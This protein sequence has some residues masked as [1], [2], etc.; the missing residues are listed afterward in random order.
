MKCKFHVNRGKWFFRDIEMESGA[1]LLLDFIADGKTEI[2]LSISTAPTEGC[3]VMK[4]Q[5]LD[6][7]QSG[8][9]YYVENYKDFRID[10]VVRLSE[11]FIYLFRELPIPHR[12][13]FKPI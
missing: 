9:Y 1:D 6:E 2:T 12:F 11:A 3:D 4:Y 10:L 13:Y 5:H 8:A 7:T